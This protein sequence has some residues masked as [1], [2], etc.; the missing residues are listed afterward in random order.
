VRGWAQ[1]SARGKGGGGG[2]ITGID[3]R[4]IL[5]IIAFNK[6]MPF[7]SGC[8]QRMLDG[9]PHRDAGHR[10]AAAPAPLVSDQ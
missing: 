6:D 8:H 9:R 2:R 3:G 7:A 4:V 10:R 5:L 1:V